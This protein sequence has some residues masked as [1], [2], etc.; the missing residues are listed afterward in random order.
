[1]AILWLG[2]LSFI[3]LCN[4]RTIDT[5]NHKLADKILLYSVGVLII[6]WAVI[7]I[8]LVQTAPMVGY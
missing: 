4:L 5:S 8:G 2:L 6:I 3:I 1:M 7:G